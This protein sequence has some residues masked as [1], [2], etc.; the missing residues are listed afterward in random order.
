MSENLHFHLRIIGAVGLAIAGIIALFLIGFGG[1]LDLREHE[2][3][4]FDAERGTQLWKTSIEEHSS[5]LH[6]MAGRIGP[7]LVRSMQRGDKEDLFTRAKP[8]FEDLKAQFGLSHWYFIGPD[9]KVILRVHQPERAG[10]MIGRRTLLDAERSGQMTS[11]LELGTNATLTLRHVMPWRVGGTLVG[12]VEMGMGIKALARDLRRATGLEVMTAVHKAFTTAEAFASGKRDMGLSGDWTAYPEMALV[13]QSL[14]RIPGSL[15]VRWQGFIRGNDPGVFDVVDEGAEWSSAFVAIHDYDRRPVAS[16]AL[17]RDVTADRAVRK[18]LQAYVAA[19]S[20]LLAALLTF[21]LW[22]LVRRTEKRVLAAHGA[23]Q[24]AE[25]IQKRVNR[26]L[27]LLNECNAALIRA[28]DESTLLDEI[29]RLVVEKGGHGMAWVGMRGF[30]GA[31]MRPVG[32]FRDR[33]GA[34]DAIPTSAGTDDPGDAL[35]EAAIRERETQVVGDLAGHR[36]P[37]LWR[38][39]AHGSNYRSCIALPLIGQYEVLGAI[40]IHSLESNAFSGEETRLLEKF[41]ADLAFGVQFLRARVARR[42]AEEALRL[43]AERFRTLFGNIRDAVFVHGLRNGRSGRFVEVNAAACRSLGYTR[44]ELLSMSPGDIDAPDSCVD[45]EP[46]LRRLVAGESVV[47]EQTHVAKNGR[48]ISVEISASNFLLNGEMQCLSLVRDV[49]EQKRARQ[50]LQDSEARL[51]KVLELMPVGVFIADRNGRIVQCNPCGEQIRAGVRH[52]GPKEL[53]A[54]NEWWADTGKPIAPEESALARAI[55]KGE[56]SI[57]EVI[58]I[59]CLDGTRKTVLNSALPWRDATGDIAGAVVVLEDITERRRMDDELRIGKE[60]FKSSF[61]SAAV[62]IVISDAQAGR[63]LMMNKA[64]CEIVGYS[65]HEL[66]GRHFAEV[67]HADDVDLDILEV[68]RLLA[69]EST[70]YIREKRY[71]HKDGNIVWVLVAVALIRDEAGGP[72]Y[73]VAQVVD[74]TARKHAEQELIASREQLRRMAAYDSGVREA[75]RKRIARELHD[76][77]GQM[78]TG[79][80][81]DLSWLRSSIPAGNAS[82]EIVRRIQGVNL[83]VDST[84]A[85]VRRISSDLRPSMLDELGLTAALEWMVEEF[86]KRY[87]PI[88]CRRVFDMNDY[89]PG[90]DISIAAY[91]I[92]QECLTNVARHA[93]ASQVDIFVDA[94]D[95]QWFVISVRDNGCG[96]RHSATAEGFGLLGMRERVMSLNGIFVLD[97]PPGGGVSLEIS[98]PILHSGAAGDST[99]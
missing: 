26:G 79:I 86:E 35:A 47:F 15:A 59:G 69:G 76:E 77:L 66:V 25:L 61:D 70:T 39:A 67:T 51:R 54:P 24:K 10:D 30:D 92:V 14:D 81:M 40:T 56:T 31:G 1:Y 53:A 88:S 45:I 64:Y 37:G 33:D 4:L 98:I 65:Q 72:M 96:L 52:A 11:G 46:I 68:P 17:L 99:G 7:E 43:S 5:R 41:A 71:L 18:R 55:E 85:S 42:E 49:S 80:K 6:W 89:R 90:A 36:A 95:D 32:C 93:Q 9:R 21:A 23:L 34:A 62:G 74:I 58:V 12:Y 94:R 91:R 50:A 87:R 8:V 29:C 28:E 27:R 48:H 57:G 82:D 84:L 19:T 44:E 22:R 16:M 73:F 97:S 2:R 20:I 3:T 83:L 63:F 75:E 60:F 78:L 38:G 13:N